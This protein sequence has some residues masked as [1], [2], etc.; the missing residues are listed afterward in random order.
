MTSRCMKLGVVIADISGSILLKFVLC[1]SF[2]FGAV[3]I[4]IVHSCVVLENL[5]SAD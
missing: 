1:S 5:Y 3:R 4:L 2:S